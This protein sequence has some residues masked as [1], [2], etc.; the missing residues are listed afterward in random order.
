MLATPQTGPLPILG[1]LRQVRAECVPLGATEHLLKV[2]VG[3]NGEGLEP[4]LIDMTFANHSPML[5]PARD[6][7]VPFSFSLD[8]DIHRRWEDLRNEPGFE[9]F[10]KSPQYRTWIETQKAK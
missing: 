5:L 7:C 2:V 8:A 3:L 9:E 10:V 1:A 6:V 4:T